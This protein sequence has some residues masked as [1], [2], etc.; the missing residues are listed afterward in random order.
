[1][2]DLTQDTVTGAVIEQMAKTTDPRLRQIMES[3]VRHL[4]A[5]AKDVQLTPE[6]WTT[7]IG[8]LTAVGQMCSPVRQEFILLS[9]VLGLSRLVNLM[10]DDETRTGEATTSSLLG[11]F[12]REAAPQLALGDTIAQH[13]TGPEIGLFGKVVDEDGKGIAH[14]SIDVWQT[15]ADGAYDLQAHD[16]AVMDNRGH[17]T[18]DAEGNFHF[19]AVRPLG[20]SIPMDGP[21]GALIKA[22]ERH[23]C[24]P[25]HIHFL[26]SAPGQRELVTALYLGDDQYIDT[27]TVFGVSAALMVTPAADQPGSPFGAMP[28]IRYDFQLCKPQAG[29]TTARVGGDPSKLTGIKTAAE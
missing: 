7:G 19:R 6:E 10:H 13:S 16:P 26:I 5:F 27:D 23:G 1:M 3:A 18:T 25:A 24:R 15:D 17:F 12:F 9:D 28:A 22:Q 4:H 21:V 8:F 11:P 2:R 29:E 14:A 20:Y